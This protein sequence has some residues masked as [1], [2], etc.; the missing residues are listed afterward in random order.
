MRYV[1]SA[2]RLTVNVMHNELITILLAQDQEEK[3]LAVSPSHPI[4]PQLA[5]HLHPRHQLLIFGGDPLEDLE[6][7]TFEE[8]GIEDGARLEIHQARRATVR[9]IARWWEQLGAHQVDG[10]HV[11]DGADC[12]CSCA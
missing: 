9:E 5:G 1:S 12:G 11:L 6:E 7:T 10:P 8:C 4:G 3:P 2:G